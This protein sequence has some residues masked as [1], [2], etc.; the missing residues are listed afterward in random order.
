MSTPVQKVAKRPRGR[1]R[2]YDPDTA[3]RRATG[4]FWRH[5]F[6]GTSLDALTDAM[7]MNRPSLYGAFGDKRA[8]YLAALDCYV[9][10]SVEQ[11]RA[12]LSED[13]PLAQGLQRVYDG[14]LA[15][16][17]TDAKAPLGCFLIGPAATEAA[18]DAA[19]RRKLGGGLAELTGRFEARF[20][21][22]RKRGEIPK[23]SD[24]AFLAEMASAVLFSIAARARG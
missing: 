18:G 19:V 23:S 5:G 9:A 14:A 15:L 11:M 1:P 16:Y 7:D 13:V 21:A 4:A 6:A 12:A 3:L 8:L 24:P 17:F 10:E 2:A 20:A 22:A